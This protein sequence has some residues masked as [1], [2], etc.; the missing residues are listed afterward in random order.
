M[1]LFF[2][3]RSEWIEVLRR[4]ANSDPNIA[5]VWVFGSRAT[6]YR[7][8]KEAPD[9]LPDL[10]VGYTLTGQNEG[11]RIAYAIFEIGRVRE[12]LQ[13]QISVRLD[14]QHAEP[15]DARVWPAILEHGVQI[16]PEAE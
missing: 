1:E 9:P 7:R 4:W 15:T 6:G 3:T 5:G 12:L 13:A 8:A 10:D 11:E 16:Y 14:L 2:E